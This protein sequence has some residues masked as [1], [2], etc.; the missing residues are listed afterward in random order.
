M[1]TNSVVSAFKVLE[2]VARMQPVGLSEL[3][4]AVELPKST[5]QRCLLTL[6]EVGW[7]AP[8]EG[9]PPRW[10]MTYRA[11]A[12]CGRAGVGRGL[13]D[14]A[15]STMNEL[16][17][18][19]TE[20]VHLCA[21]DGDSLVLIE[22]LD[23]SHPL[24]AFLPLGERISLHASA[25]GL[26]YL[27]ACDPAVVDE[28]LAGPLAAS[29][30]DSITDPGRLREVLAEVAA[31]GYS[32]N[33]GGLSAGISSIGAP[34]LDHGGT[35]VGAISVSG[36]SSRMVEERFDELGPQVA[37]AAARIGVLLQ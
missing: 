23:T 10:Q 6:Q 4:R 19:T 11:I 27:S 5:T 37:A 22:R 9:S 2:A 8:T 34:I 33:I 20:T 15:I 29:T 32:T 21:P 1:A 17:L 3:A 24:R 28:Y 13:R 31:R 7:L 26:A 18:A 35:P 14:V 16:Q 30:P 25:T 36:P 12:V